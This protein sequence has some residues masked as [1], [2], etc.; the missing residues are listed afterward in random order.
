MLVAGKKAHPR[1]APDNPYSSNLM[2]FTP[3]RA[4]GTFLL[5]LVMPATALHAQSVPL[6]LT[7]RSFSVRLPMSINASPSIWDAGFVATPPDAGEIITMPLDGVS[8]ASASPRKTQYVPGV[9][10]VIARDCVQSEPLR[11]AYVFT[12]DQ[13]TGENYSPWLDEQV[14]HFRHR[15]AVVFQIPRPHA[16]RPPSCR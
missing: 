8:A 2:S 7:S 11:N 6:P 10:S 3:V 1:L 12:D 14:F 5:A 13:L 4:L 16:Q 15:F 9:W